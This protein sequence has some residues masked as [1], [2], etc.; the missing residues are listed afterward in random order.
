MQVVN[1]GIKS[2]DQVMKEFGEAYEAAR[3][4]KPYAPRIGVSFSSLEVA[5][6]VLTPKRLAL[7]R[8]IKK[9]DPKSLYALAKHARRNFSSVLRDVEFLVQHGLIIL[10]RERGSPR[11]SIRPNVGYDAINLWIGI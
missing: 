5:R 2:M 9:H 7:L 3:L 8:L 10:R 4:R 11:R 6:R 1:Y